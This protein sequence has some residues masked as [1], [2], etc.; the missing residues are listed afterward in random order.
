MRMKTGKQ[1]NTA[2]GA[3]RR[4]V[5]LVGTYRGDQLKAWPGWYCWPLAGAQCCQC[6]SVASGQFQFPMMAKLATGNIGIGNIH[7]MATL[8]N[9]SPTGV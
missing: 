4:R 6:E 7:T 9:L 2:D 1:T 8:G 3:A 5:V